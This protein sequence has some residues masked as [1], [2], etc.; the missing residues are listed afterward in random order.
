MVAIGGDPSLHDHEYDRVAWFPVDQ[1]R[2]AL[3]Y[4]NEAD[5]VR[6]VTERSAHLHA[7]AR[8]AR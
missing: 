7:G 3:R 6:R 1:A 5:L 4:S 2:E 8:Q